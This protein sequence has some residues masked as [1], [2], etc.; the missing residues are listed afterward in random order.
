[1]LIGSVMNMVEGDVARPNTSSYSEAALNA[2]GRTPEAHL[3]CYGTITRSFWWAIVTMTT[4][5]YGDC[6]PVTGWGS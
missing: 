4:V 5:G 3:A 2:M 1:M 6:Y